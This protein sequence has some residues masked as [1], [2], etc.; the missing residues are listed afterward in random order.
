MKKIF[1]LLLGLSCFAHP[2]FA[3]N[4]LVRN[5]D[6][7]NHYVKLL[8]PGDT[9]TLANGIWKDVNLVFRA[10][11]TEKDSIVL[12]AQTPGKVILEGE[13]TLTLDGTYLHVDGLLFTNG[14]GNGDY[15]ISFAAKSTNPSWHCRVSNCA[16]IDY[17]LPD[18]FPGDDWV[19]IY[20]R[21]NRF[22]HNYLAGKLNAGRCVVVILND[23]KSQNNYNRID[24]NYFGERKRL[25]SNGG[26]TIRIGTSTYSMTNAHTIV[27]S[28]FFEHCNGEVE[29]ISIKSGDNII[30]DN[31]FYECEGTVT[32]RHGNG[33]K[34][35]HNIFIGNGKPFTGGVRVINRDHLIY[36]NYFFKMAGDRV[37]SALSVMN[38]VPHSAINRYLS[39][40]N[41]KIYHNTF[42]DCSHIEFGVDKD[43]ERTAAPKSTSFTDNI[44]Y[45]PNN[46]DPVSIIDSSSQI[47]FSH[48]LLYAPQSHLKICGFIRTDM[49]IKKD[50]SGLYTV[51]LHHLTP[52]QKVADI[53]KEVLV[54]WKEAGPSWLNTYLSNER[55]RISV[56]PTS[57]RVD[58]QRNQLEEA[59]SSAHAGDTILLT[60]SGNYFLSKPLIVDKPLVIMADPH[61]SS[62]PVLVF[63]TRKTEP[64]I[65]I[66]EDG[67]KLFVQG[68]VFNGRNQFRFKSERG[69]LAH[70]MI[71]HYDLKVNDCDFYNYTESTYS[72]FKAEKGSFAD[73]IVFCNSLFYNISGPAINLASE[74]DNV[75]IYSAS[76]ITLENCIFF[77]VMGPALNLYRGGNDESTTGPFLRVDHC[78]FE[79]VNNKELGATLKLIG[80]Q[81]ANI[82]NSIFSNSGRGGRSILFQ[83]FSYNYNRVYNCDFYNSGKIGSF[84]DNVISGKIYHVKPIYA[85]MNKFN[86]MIM[87]KKELPGVGLLPKNMVT[88]RE[89]FDPSVL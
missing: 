46:P 9:I 2:V 79:D 56:K 40:K 70:S 38:G 57:I 4:Y 66:I 88:C 65:I 50:V 37:R 47:Y 18:R 6:E 7:F 82:T 10:N 13:S 77:R 23:P 39:V 32:L 49:G 81:Y 5:I 16:I 28:N 3:T 20:G 42:I 14:H 72:G 74:N 64:A 84:Y 25:G 85:D 55:N 31:A 19:A 61:L 58:N 67:G 22:D 53:P 83:S 36:D 8:K 34:I 1:A 26:E 63:D 15:V 80:V 41:V 52:G 17:N 24:H 86:F 33:N 54:Q 48:N 11:G 51:V 78:V 89:Q 62:K 30:K 69:I 44:I 43:M 71:H 73:S 12:Q 68:I 27:D 45:A 59:V 75:G 60:S 35:Y 29:I 21:Y 76:Y 87:N